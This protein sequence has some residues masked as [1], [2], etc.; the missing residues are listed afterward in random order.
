MTKIDPFEPYW[1]SCVPGAMAHYWDMVDDGY[2]EEQLRLHRMRFADMACGGDGEIGWF[3]EYDDPS[4]EGRVYRDAEFQDRAEF[5]DEFFQEV[6]I[7]M[8]WEEYLFRR[9]DL[10]PKPQK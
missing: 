8:K 5:P 6:C 2:P 10:K 9:E 1:R 3:T 7:L 4:G